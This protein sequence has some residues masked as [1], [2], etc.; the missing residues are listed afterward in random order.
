MELDITKVALAQVTDQY[1]EYLHH[2]QERDAAQVSAFLVIA[3]KLLQ[4]KSESLLPRPVVHEPGE[5][6][7]GE[8]L[9]QQL[10]LYRTFKRVAGWLTQREVD[11]QRTYLHVAPPPRVRI[12]PVPGEIS[13]IDLLKG[14]QSV[15]NLTSD[16]PLLNDVVSIP[17]ITIRE[18]IQFVLDRLRH[19]SKM[20]FR[21]LVSPKT[22]K[23]DVVVTFLAILEL[24]KRHI[25]QVKQENLFADIE[26]ELLQEW[27]PPEEFDLE[28]EE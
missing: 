2:L 3:A 7:L 12:K 5:E 6:D 27:I 8:A 23:I 9:A 13:L 4:I 24:I 21:D 17:M 19:Y 25:I 15:V 1:L 16:T 11:H 22:S 26:L 18:K 28:F 20:T 14:A 10:I